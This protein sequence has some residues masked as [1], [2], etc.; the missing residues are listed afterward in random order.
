MGCEEVRLLLEQRV[1]ACRGEVE[2]LRGEVERIAVLA[3]DREAELTRLATALE[4][5]TGL[6]MLHPA[7]AAVAVVSDTLAPLPVAPAAKPCGDKDLEKF[8]IDVLGA[9]RAGPV[10]GMR[11]G[12]LIAAMG[13][14]PVPRLVER[15]RHRGKR[16]VEQGILVEEP[17]GMFALPPPRGHS[18]G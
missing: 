16:L 7:T 5:V 12:Q 18:Q 8:T 14:D 1:A 3:T 2:W 4:V 6:P 9:L 17:A 13:L 10:G 15:A 11:C